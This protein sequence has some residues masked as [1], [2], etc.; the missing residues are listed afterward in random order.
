MVY[1]CNDRL[2]QGHIIITNTA[3]NARLIYILHGPNDFLYIFAALSETLVL[4]N[5]VD[6]NGPC[7]VTCVSVC[8][9]STSAQ[10]LNSCACPDVHSRTFFRSF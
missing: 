10:W 8:D 9:M 4:R 5:T 3:L 2:D 6:R 1:S 7:H